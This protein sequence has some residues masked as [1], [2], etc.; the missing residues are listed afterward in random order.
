MKRKQIYIKQL[1]KFIFNW[2]SKFVLLILGMLFVCISTFAVLVLISSKNPN[3]LFHV[4]PSDEKLISNFYEHSEEFE[5]LAK[6]LILENE[7]E[8]IYPDTSTCQISNQKMIN[9]ADS[10]SCA[11][12]IKIFRTLGL[13]WAYT[14]LWAGNENL[15]LTVSWS[16]LSVSGSTKGYYYSMV[17]I[18]PSA[19]LSENTDK[20]KSR[21]AF[22][23]IEGNWYIFLMR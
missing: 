14:Q 11:N 16:G 2:A 6:M 1:A 21:E 10:L 9:S 15:W 4:H 23:Y 5:Q 17:G 19:V 22:H 13:D 18:P 12:Y 20:A 3:S 7:I 8:V